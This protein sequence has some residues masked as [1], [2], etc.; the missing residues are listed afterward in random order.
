MNIILL[1]SI[2]LR[3]DNGFFDRL[4]DNEIGFKH[5]N[6]IDSKNQTYK[7]QNGIRTLIVIL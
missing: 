1:C 4:I 5:D 3:P 6:D 7:L 2:I